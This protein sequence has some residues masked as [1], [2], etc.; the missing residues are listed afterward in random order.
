MR[1][2]LGLT[3]IAIILTLISANL[4]A[5][6]F[7][8]LPDAPKAMPSQSQITYYLTLTVN[9]QTDQEIIPVIYRN[10]HYFVEAG[11]LAR[12]HV[13]TNGI[14]SGLVNL[15][16]LSE[17]ITVYD[18]AHQQLRLTVPDNWL[19]EQRIQT[20]DYFSRYPPRSSFGMLQNYDIY[21]ITA[22][23]NQTSLSSL[24]EQRVFSNYGYLT[25]TGIY[26]QKM[27][28]MP[29]MASGYVRFDTYWRYSD[30]SN[31]VSVQVGD[32]VSNA[33]TWSNANRMGGLRISRQFG[34]RP[35]LV[36]YPMLQ[37]SGSAAIPS[38][39]DLFINGNKAGTSNINAGPY[40]LN[41][42]P[43]INGQ[44]E[45][46]IV[47]TDALG[48][49]FETTIP[50]YVSNR[51]LREGLSDFDMSLGVMRHRHG[52]D[53]AAY[54]GAA[55][56]GIY[57]YGLNNKLTLSG[58]A[59]LS[60]E[61][62]LAGVGTDFVLG[63]WGTIS[64]AYS[65]S[66]S[67]ANNQ[68]S[69]GHQYVAG[70]SFFSNA[71]NITA[72]HT[73]RS[74]G[75]EDLSSTT[76]NFKLSSQFSQ[77]T[78]SMQPFG[79]NNG[80]AGI[81]Y[82][83]IREHDNHRTRLLNLSYSVPVLRTSNLNM[84]V[85]KTIG[86]GYSASVQLSIPFDLSGSVNVSAQRDDNGNLLKRIN[87]SRS[88]PSS[89]GLGWGLGY[90]IGNGQYRHADLTWKG[91]RATMKGGVY[92][93]SGQESYWGNLTGSLIWMDNTMFASNKI[94]DAFI[95]VSTEGYKDVLVRYENQPIGRTGDTGHILIPWVS[96]YHPGSL[97]IE[98]LSLPID[99]QTP[100]V[101]QRVAVKESSGTV[102]SFPVYK[103]RPAMV[104]LIDADGGFIPL[105]S[106]VSI[107]GS[108][109]YG[110]VGHDGLAYFSHLQRHNQIV[111]DL[112]NNEQCQL[113]VHV[114]D[115]SASLPEI[116]PLSCLDTRA[117]VEVTQ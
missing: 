85:N 69:S 34:I 63:R 100:S 65:R 96:A 2:Q 78:F 83:D 36:T 7:S 19:P 25:N 29:G 76:N 48:R 21:Y 4:S 62:R 13:R 114:P 101:E 102:V 86:A 45:A 37:Y 47:T 108:R 115:D 9:G 10:K 49:Q 38:S 46:T 77:M 84:S 52:T 6:N 92:G 31:M 111:I 91:Q 57:R 51:L 17:V 95:V 42:V 44:G 72:Q 93:N 14:T 109:Q 18:S 61:L 112:P 59:E 89:G 55:F 8:S 75:Y 103:V 28:N 66:N 88:A 64:T 33:L 30:E 26:R 53:N 11:I 35:D 12:N 73:R 106:R 99:V 1:K 32:F 82:F 71:F 113:T 105:G 68:R 3:C 104:R 116:G 90:A 79:K 20:G 97:D 67:T 43:F 110:V 16:T 15:D 94:N 23:N 81:G 58:H 27:H 117:T 98:T 107:L 50:F 5:Q 24:L 70:Y 41:N 54:G 22:P 56:S 74:N 40:T 39:I 60:K 80:I 87:A